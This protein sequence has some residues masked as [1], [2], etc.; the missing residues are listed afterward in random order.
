MVSRRGKRKRT[1]VRQ[2]FFGSAAALWWEGVKPLALRQTYPVGTVL[3]HQG[4][5]AREVLLLERGMVKLVAMGEQGRPVIVGMRASGWL[6]GAAAVLLGQPYAATA[7]TVTECAIRH[8]E[9]GTFRRLVQT[10]AEVAGE[11]LWRKRVTKV[12]QRRRPEW[13]NEEG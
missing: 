7:E 6:I 3:V 4:M 8:L 1:D 9:A 12:R 11:V 13:Q 10:E 2:F 5:P